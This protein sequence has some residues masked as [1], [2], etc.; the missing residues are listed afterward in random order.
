MSYGLMVIAVNLLYLGFSLLVGF[1]AAYLVYKI[2]KKRKVVSGLVFVISF[3]TVLLAPFYDL[4]IQK[5]IKTYYETYK[6]DDTIYAYPEKDENGKIESLNIAR[7]NIFPIGFFLNRNGQYDYDFNSESS[8][9][10]MKLTNYYDDWFK[11]NIADYIELGIEDDLNKKKLF[12]I[13]Y[14]E[15]MPIHPV[16]VQDATYQIKIQKTPCEASECM[17]SEYV[18]L[19]IKSDK[20]LATAWLLYFPAKKDTFRYK[21][22]LW[23]GA[24]GVP[25]SISNIGNVNKIFE[26]IFGFTLK[27]GGHSIN[28]NQKGEALSITPL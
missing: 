3:L 13:I 4:I 9:K 7:T 2:T 27:V 5:S 8:L 28:Y 12:R 6:M 23:H 11:N 10:N 24:N 14:D 18:F 1:V 21:F 26:K 25:F 15:D 19:N 16:L 20:V 22:L 17:K